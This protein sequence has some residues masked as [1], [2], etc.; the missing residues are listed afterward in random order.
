MMTKNQKQ[1]AW[2]LVFLLGL[3]FLLVCVL[4]SGP[5]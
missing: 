4:V 2:L 5:E 1:A 3:V